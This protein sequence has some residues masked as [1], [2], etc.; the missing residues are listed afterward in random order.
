VLLSK[1]HA[2]TRRFLADLSQRIPKKVPGKGQ[3]KDMSKALAT[4]HVATIAVVLALA[5]GFTFAFATP[6]KAVT[7]EEL[8]AQIQGLLA[9]IASL[10]S[11]GSTGSTGGT[12]FTFTQTLRQGSTGAEVMQLQKFLNSK[13]FTVAATGAGSPGNETSYFGPATKAAVI[14]FQN[15]NAAQILTPVGLTAGTGIWGPSSRAA[16]NA[17]CTGGTTGGTTTP[18][19]TGAGLSIMAGSQPANSLAPKGAARVPFTTFVLT[20]N[21]GSVVTVNGVT[22]ERTGLAQDAAFSGVVLIDS[23]NVQLGTSKT[24]NSNHQ[25]TIGDT[26]TLNPGETK[27]L[28]VAGNMA[29]SLTSY[30]GQVAGIAVVGINTSVPVSGSLPISGAQQTLNDTLTIG[31]VSTS[32][33]SFDPGA[34]QTK[35]IGDTAVRFSGIRFTA[36]SGEDLKLYS[37]RW[38]Q[39]GTAAGSDISNVV[40]V[41]NGTSYPATVSS[42]GKYYTSVFPGGI[43]ITKGNSVD[44]YVQG[45]LTGTNSASRTVDMDIDKVTDVYFVGQLYGYGIAPSGTYTPWYNGKVTT[46]QGGTATTIGKANEVPS[47]NIAVNVANQPLGGF[48]TDFKGEPVSVTQMV[49]NFNLSSQDATDRLLT[50]VSLVDENGVVVAGPKDAVDNAGTAMTVTFTDTVTFPVGRKVYTLK[51]RV[52]SDV[53]DGQTITAST[54]PSGWS[55][56]TGQVS[57]N[58]VTISQGNFSMNPMTVRAAALAVSVSSSPAST[59]I[60]AGGQGITFANIQF[61]ATQSGE[62]VRFSSFTLDSDGDNL[63]LAGSLAN[64]STCQ[65]FDGATPLNTG[66]NVVN[67][68]TTATTTAGVD[69]AFTLDA[70]LT[71]PKGTVKTLTIK[72]NVSSN[73]D[74]NAQY[75]I[76]M[77][78]TNIAAIAATGVTSGNSV[79][80]TGSGA[81]GQV[82][83]VA[84]AGTVTL[85]SQSVD[86]SQPALSRVPA[87]TSGVT[88]GNMKISATNESVTIQK[89]GLA[90]GGTA[91]STNGRYGTNS[92]G[93]AGSSNSGVGDVVKAYIYN[94]AT[95]L[96]EATFTGSSQ[97]ATSTLITPLVIPANSDVTL[98]IKADLAP[99]SV[100]DT[101]GIGDVVA[102]DPENAQ[103]VGNQSGSQINVPAA[104][105]NG[106]N[107]VQMTKSVPTVALGTGACSGNACNGANQVLKVFTV[108]A[109]QAG[110]VSIWRLIFNIATTS[111]SASST[112]LTVLDENGNTATSTFGVQ[113]DGGVAGRTIFTGGPL[114]IPAGKTYTFKLTGTVTPLSGVT[115]WSV[116]TTL[117]GTSTNNKGVGTSP[118]TIATTTSVLATQGYEFIWSDNA[119]TTASINTVDWFGGAFI[120]G[121]PSTGI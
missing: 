81:N 45:D 31:T 30:T 22:V 24:F 97:S 76:G 77:G 50:S 100:S 34:A 112:L 67:P 80:P 98:T 102:I 6:A 74:A 111:A 41:V 115:N 90:L 26:F 103:G 54:T 64:L 106:V 61:N 107:G 63:A 99:I 56:P 73:A 40:T 38:R 27:T 79:T 3:H 114:I 84:T 116:V 21:S 1:G 53:S 109:N 51:G 86:V 72:C 70:P 48:V 59:T 85:T 119:T 15:A 110:P 60:V 89:I 82:M 32:S 113:Q 104:N 23:N 18:P 96:G 20:N 94:G 12:C 117:L 78:S 108:T 36:G 42:D 71:V 49:F 9:Q 66:S 88:I 29:S 14:K 39:V 47:Q 69:I 118:S 16:A 95:L 2:R 121:L 35:S 101:G 43:L 46:I 83:Q 19:P 25:A 57:G 10:Q 52:D 75:Q 4:K 13:G 28:T 5:L 11:G 8:Q 120:N 17:M 68:S 7:I 55:S 105:T 37:V 91:T 44:V 93:S 65:A 92:T 62:D 58:S 87:G 33:S